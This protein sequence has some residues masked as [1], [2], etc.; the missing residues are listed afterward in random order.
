MNLFNCFQAVAFYTMTP[1]L[2]EW[3]YKNDHV[4][5]AYILGA[6]EF[7]G[8]VLMSIAISKVKDW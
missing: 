6:G 2:I 7:I 3:L 8:F 1:F 4:A 5:W